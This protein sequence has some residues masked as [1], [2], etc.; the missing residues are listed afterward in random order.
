M[1][2][3]AR[4][5]E[6]WSGAR[7]FATWPLILL[8]A[9]P[10]C[11]PSVRTPHVSIEHEV[12]LEK[13]QGCGEQGITLTRDGG[14]I[15]AGKVFEA[16]ATRVTAQGEIL[17]RYVEP[18]DPTLG[19]RDLSPS[20]FGGAVLLADDSVVLC[21]GKYTSEGQLG[22]VV[23]ISARGEV[24]DRETLTPKG[25]AP[26]GSRF[27]KCV[28]WEGGA[29]LLGSV[30]RKPRADGWLV[31]LDGVGRK[32]WEAVGQDY[33]GDDALE[34][35][36][37]SL[38]MGAAL[39]GPLQLVRVS[40]DGGL[41]RKRIMPCAS[42]YPGCFFTLFHHV[43]PSPDLRLVSIDR[44]HATIYH[45]DGALNDLDP[46]V[47]E[48]PSMLT[49]RA[50]QLGDG[51]GALFGAT[52]Y[53]G[54]RSDATVGYVARTGQLSRIYEWQPTWSQN[55]LEIIEESITVNDAA[56]VSD[57]EFVA[58]RDWAAQSPRTYL[59]WISIR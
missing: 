59:D 31:K 47:R 4:F 57:A 34:L 54:G 16:C 3:L 29:A 49:N 36:D 10:G 35:A 2:R 5:C 41:Q 48:R 52:L 53:L 38:V 50:F 13:G 18:H 39:V 26:M 8:P 11:S 27:D 14:L 43:K 15:L 58:V 1:S 51:G 45:L 44:P 55:H 23:R 17:W 28:P 6:R 7:G 22:L 24:L 32:V 25:G 20:S 46:P 30:P 40:P 37:H 19:K 12:F 21:G 33:L 56:A 42:V 9:M